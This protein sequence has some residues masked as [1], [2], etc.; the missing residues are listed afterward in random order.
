MPENAAPY[1]D[2][3]NSFRQ[4]IAEMGLDGF[5]VHRTDEYQG[6]FIAACAERVAWLTGFT[7][8]TGTV[9]VLKDRAVVFTDGR[10]SIQVE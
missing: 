1:Q 2:R 10:Y 8:S 3:L 7:G 9:I 4:K 6:E 5:I